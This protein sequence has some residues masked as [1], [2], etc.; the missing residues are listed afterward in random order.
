MVLLGITTDF[1]INLCS[2]LYSL[3]LS[4]PSPELSEHQSTRQR[5]ETAAVSNTF[6]VIKLLL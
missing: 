1:M 6:N 2:E 5:I 4:D 3:I